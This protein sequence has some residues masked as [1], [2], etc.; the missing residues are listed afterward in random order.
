MHIE[1]LRLLQ[2]IIMVKKTL[3][4]RNEKNNVYMYV[5]TCTVS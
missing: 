2:A 1:M 3:I 4:S 5:G